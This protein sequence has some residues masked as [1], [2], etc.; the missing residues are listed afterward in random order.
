MN[1]VRDSRFLFLVMALTGALSSGACGDDD[2]DG[3][4]TAGSSSAGRS[5]GT[6]LGG[7]TNEG[8][9]GFGGVIPTDGGEPSTPG[10]A[11]SGGA[12][13]SAAAGAA[14]QA[15]GGEGGAAATLSLSDAQVLLVLDTLNQ[16]EVET[17]YAALPRLAEVDVKAFA[18]QM[19][20]DHG[21]A[22]QSV[23]AVADS[24]DLDPLPSDVQSML[25]QKAEAT[26]QTFH[27]SQAATLDQPYVDSQVADHAAALALLGELTATAN[28]AELKE[29]IATLETSVQAHYDHIRELE[30]AL[31]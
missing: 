4:G 5:G 16:G 25:K 14:G 21:A 19:I 28:E 2:D 23:L 13:E 15:I 24:L 7:G 6:G 20:T 12:G 27:A 26:I 10:G 1:Q 9:G 3:A 8:E 18:Q 17:A 29:L 30:A 11:T 22:R 31:P